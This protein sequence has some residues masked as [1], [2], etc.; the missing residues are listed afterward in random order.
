MTDPQSAPEF[1][2]KTTP[3]IYCAVDTPNLT[4]A[5]SLAETLAGTGCGVKLGLEFFNAHGPQGIAKV[6]ACAPDIPLFID[7]KYHDIPNTVAGAVRSILPL[8]PAYINVHAS[9]GAAM[10]QAAKEAAAKGAIENNLPAPKFLAVTIL[11]SMDEEALTQAGFVGGMSDRVLQLA[12]LAKECG[13]DGVVCSAHEIEAIREA[14]GEDFILMVPGIRPAGSDTGDQ[15]RIMTPQNALKAGA[16][17]LVI[18]R[19]ITQSNDP[20]QAAR[21]IIES[22]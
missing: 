21:D 14:C 10:M 4:K 13:M 3:L 19:P 9:G 6:Q 15:K 2:Q 20:A 17:H 7:L 16:T 5:I 11:T 22:L 18:G 8:R 1:N 12:K